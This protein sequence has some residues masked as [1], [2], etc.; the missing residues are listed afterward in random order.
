MKTIDWRNRIFIGD[1][2]IRTRTYSIYK[3][4]NKNFG[5]K[6]LEKHRISDKR[7]FNFQFN[8]KTIIYK[9]RKKKLKT[10]LQNKKKTN[11][12]QQNEK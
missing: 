12:Q 4:I 9:F 2:H 8:F 5:I 3:Y 6:K 7:K 10:R 1:M 11:N